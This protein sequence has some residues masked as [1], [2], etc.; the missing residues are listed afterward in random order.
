MFRSVAS[1]IVGVHPQAH[2]L[3]ASLGLYGRVA[4]HTT[5]RELTP[6]GHDQTTLRSLFSWCSCRYLWPSCEGPSGGTQA[7]A[8]S[9]HRAPVVQDLQM[10]RQ[11]DKRRSHTSHR[12]SRS[13]GKRSDPLPLTNQPDLRGGP[14]GR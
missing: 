11:R 3:N 4:L 6:P 8:K 1:I 7:A 13:L 5:A 2:G 9:A 10:V 12:L 14:G